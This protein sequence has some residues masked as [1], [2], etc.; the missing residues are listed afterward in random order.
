[1]WDIWNGDF[2]L[3]TVYSI[4][5]KDFFESRGYRVVEVEMA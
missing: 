2:F 3:R 4:E 5:D 1:M